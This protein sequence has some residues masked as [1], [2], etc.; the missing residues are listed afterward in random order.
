MS[1]PSR[2][3]ERAARSR[4]RARRLSRQLGVD[5]VGIFVPAVMSVGLLFWVVSEAMEVLRIQ[6]RDA[7]E[8]PA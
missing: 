2:R 5:R 8:R 6:A 4:R 7:R 3:E 1:A